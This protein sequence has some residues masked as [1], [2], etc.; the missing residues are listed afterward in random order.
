MNINKPHFTR[1]DGTC[2]YIGSKSCWQAGHIPFAG[3]LLGKYY[4]NKAAIVIFERYVRMKKIVWP[5]EVQRFIELWRDKHPEIAIKGFMNHYGRLDY[6]GAYDHNGKIN[7]LFAGAFIGNEEGILYGEPFS[8]KPEDRDKVF[9]ELSTALFRQFIK[10]N[11]YVRS[12]NF[13]LN[14]PDQSH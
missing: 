10:S 2:D 6:W 3:Y 14:H 9:F 8:P 12:I 13:K 7:R 11:Y 4:G 1:C 5:D